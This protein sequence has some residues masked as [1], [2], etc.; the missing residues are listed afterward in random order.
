MFSRSFN[1][2]LLVISINVDDPD[3]LEEGDQQQRHGAGVSVKDVE[4]VHS[5]LQREN[6]SDSEGHEAEDR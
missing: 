4:D 3:R 2:F 6:G 1:V 5:R